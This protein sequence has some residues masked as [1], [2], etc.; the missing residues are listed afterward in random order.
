[1]GGCGGKP[2]SKPEEKVLNKVEKPEPQPIVYHQP[3]P[4]AVPQV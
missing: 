4:I 2:Q 3:E 1:M